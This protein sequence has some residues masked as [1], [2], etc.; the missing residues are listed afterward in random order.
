MNALELSHISLRYPDG[1]DILRDVSFS[2]PQGSFHF[3]TG[4]SGAGKSSLLRICY[5][6]ERPTAGKL[7]IDGQDPATLSR[8]DLPKLRRR[9]GV[10]FQDFRL[11]QH[12]TVAEN[13]A[14][15]LIVAGVKP[16]EALEHVRELLSWS[17]V[18]DKTTVYPTELSG[19][20]QQRVAI[21]RAVINRPK[22]LLADEPTGNID[23]A[24]A[25]RVMHLFA[26]LHK[27]GTTIILATHDQNLLEIYDY[28]CLHLRGGQLQHPK[29]IKEQAA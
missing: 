5:L 29:M 12:L 28:P 21:A 15:P 8:D 17:G 6:M 18:G 10:V 9:V 19:G 14:L 27:M 2:C 22:L 13:V 26:E 23:D 4:P 20:Q 24:G 25:E 7:L 3:L 11:L 1:K 16:K